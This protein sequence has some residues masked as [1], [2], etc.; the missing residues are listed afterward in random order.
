M[1]IRDAFSGTKSDEN[2]YL[3]QWNVP[4]LSQPFKARQDSGPSLFNGVYVRI[5]G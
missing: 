1:K 5:P 3:S 4:S 2:G